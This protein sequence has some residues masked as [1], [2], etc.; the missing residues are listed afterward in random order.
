MGLDID[1]LFAGE[2]SQNEFFAS[3]E[4]QSVRAKYVAKTIDTEVTGLVSF[5]FFGE[6]TTSLST[7]DDETYGTYFTLAADATITTITAFVNGRSGYSINSQ[8]A[9]Y[10]KA[11]LALLGV[12]DQLSLA[13]AGSPYWKTW[14]LT[15]PLNLTAGDYLIVM[16]TDTNPSGKFYY[17]ASL[18][19][20]RSSTMHD[21]FPITTTPWSGAF[22]LDYRFCIHTNVAQS[23]PTIEEDDDLYFNLE[24]NSIYSF[25]LNIQVSAVAAGIDFAFCFNA[26]AGFVGKYWLTGVNPTD[27]G[28]YTTL[29]AGTTPA[30]Y[31]IT[32]YIATGATAGVL[33]LKYKQAVFTEEQAIK[34]YAGSWAMIDKK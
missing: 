6:T 25:S 19:T 7:T 31:T 32:G 33:Q 21:L 11:T 22:T 16:D 5:G 17:T 29:T 13:Y 20:D 26:P 30:W 28:T 15:S 8:C 18:G 12:T 27:L 9:I 1:N 24:E 2:D 23:D 14:T 34:L 4:D 10:S 3:Y